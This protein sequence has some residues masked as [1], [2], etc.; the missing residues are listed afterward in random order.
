MIGW[1]G[2]T[3]AKA[4]IRLKIGP[5]QNLNNFLMISSAINWFSLF[6]STL[7]K[8][9][10]QVLFEGVLLQLSDGCFKRS[11]GYFVSVLQQTNAAS[12]RDS[13]CSPNVNL[14]EIKLFKHL[15]CRKHSAETQDM[16]SRWKIFC[17]NS[18]AAIRAV[19]FLPCVTI[20]IA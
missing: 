20:V 14:F 12:V 7:S 6:R 4:A 1:S 2:G 18:F 17:F 19:L 5:G 9:V 3:C 10:W 13:N 16:L 8:F 15:V 11:D